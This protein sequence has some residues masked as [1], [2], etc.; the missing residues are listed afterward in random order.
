MK[1]RNKKNHFFL[2]P[3][4]FITFFFTIDLSLW[5]AVKILNPAHHWLFTVLIIHVMCLCNFYAV[6]SMLFYMVKPSTWLQIDLNIFLCVKL[7]I[8]RFTPQRCAMF[9]Y[10]CTEM[11]ICYI[12]PYH[13]IFNINIFLTVWFLWLLWWLCSCLLEPK[14]SCIELNNVLTRISLCISC[15]NYL[16][17][18]RVVMKITMFPA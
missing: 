1:R 3:I 6:Y 9:Q 15:T 16:I 18:N 8:V 7:E 13:I 2:V 11:Y 10:F 14:T 5:D 17:R 4:W 12:F